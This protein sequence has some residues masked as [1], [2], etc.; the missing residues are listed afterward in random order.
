MPT[1]QLRG[2]KT[3]VS[4]YSMYAVAG[5]LVLTVKRTTVPSLGARFRATMSWMVPP[6]VVVKSSECG[7]T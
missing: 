6:W 3:S 7:D 4:P 1:S 5:S 2:V